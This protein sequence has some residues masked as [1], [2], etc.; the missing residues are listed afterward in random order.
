[1]GGG[2]RRGGRRVGP[3][4]PPA[5]AAEPIA[6]ASRRGEFVVLLGGDCSILLGALLGLWNARAAPAGLVY[7]DAHADFATLAESPSHSACSMNLA[8]AAGRVDGPL[9][10]LAG[11]GPLVRGEHVVHIGPRDDAQPP[12]GYPP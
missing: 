11:D 9:A 2:G 1:G 6:P 12:S 3:P 10:R 7:I 5:G 8:L 4:P